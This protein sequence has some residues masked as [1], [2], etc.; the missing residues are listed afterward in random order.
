VSTVNYPII[1][2]FEHNFYN[3]IINFIFSDKFKVLKKLDNYQSIDDI[4]KN[5]S[6]EKKIEQIFEYKNLSD[7]GVE[8]GNLTNL[9]KNYLKINI[10]KVF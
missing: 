5:Y 4:S 10:F 1:N 3:F 7:T 8:Y 6:I 9:G 2:N